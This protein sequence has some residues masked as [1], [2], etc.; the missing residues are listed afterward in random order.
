MTPDK[1]SPARRRAGADGFTLVE[2]LVAMSIVALVTPLLI[3]G[4][5]SSLT[6][7]RQ[8][9]DRGT[10]TV[11]AQAEVELLRAQCFERLA[12]SARKIV[13]AAT[14]PGEPPLPAGFAAGYVR[15]EPAGSAGL[16]AT[17]SLYRRDW[18]GA[19]P[20]GP[21]SF[22]TSTYLADVRVAGACP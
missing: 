19:D 11:W 6:R 21:P 4:L 1:A 3:G 18:A 22:S 2:V 17:V 16:K 10:A 5:I 20:P 12:P 14:Q 15:L 7:A 8:S 9:E 13:P